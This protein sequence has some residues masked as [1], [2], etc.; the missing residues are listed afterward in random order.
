MRPIRTCRDLGAAIRQAR[1]DQGL[2]QAAL[3]GR[4]RVSRPWLSEVETGKRTAEVGRVM[5]VL[6]ALGLAVTIVPADHPDAFD[7][8]SYIDNWNN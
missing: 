6:D 2:T 3:A 1:I 5:W 8:N 7:L 4:A